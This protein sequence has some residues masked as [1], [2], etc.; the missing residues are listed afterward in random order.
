MHRLF[1]MPLQAK[2]WFIAGAVA[3]L[4]G[5]AATQ[6][7]TAAVAPQAPEDA[8][9]AR[10]QQR[11]DAL[12]K[13]DFRAAYEFLSP[14]TRQVE[15]FESYSGLLRP[16]FWKDAQIK[17]VTCKPEAD[18][19]EVATTI[20]YVFQGMPVTTPLKESWTRSGGQWWYVKN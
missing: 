9:R 12:L 15:S 20:S 3:L 16:G 8:V 11:W 1:R 4:A 7:M 14:G 13:N 19:C 17:G 2:S 6:P 10:A 18:V 5:C